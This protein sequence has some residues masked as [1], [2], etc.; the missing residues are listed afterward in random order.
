MKL[1]LNTVRL[2]LRW[3]EK[4]LLTGRRGRPGK[5]DLGSKSL[6]VLVYVLPELI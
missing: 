3:I 4:K 1:V 6:Q 2:Y 5:T